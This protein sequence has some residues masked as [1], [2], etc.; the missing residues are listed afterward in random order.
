MINSI[1]APG[2]RIALRAAIALVLLMMFAGTAAAAESLLVISGNGTLFY[3]VWPAAD[4]GYLLGG[5][6]SDGAMIAKIDSAGREE[7][8]RSIPG[9]SP[10]EAAL[11]IQQTADGGAI[12]FSSSQHLIR[13]DAAGETLWRFAVTANSKVRSLD[14][15]SDGGFILAGDAEGGFLLKASEAG[16]EVWNQSYGCAER[17]QLRSVQPTEDGGF[18]LGGFNG[19][20]SGDTANRGLLIKTDPEGSVVWR[21]EYVGTD[22]GMI[23]STQPVPDGG[24]VAVRIAIEDSAVGDVVYRPWLMRTDG[25][26]TVLWQKSFAGEAMALY[27][28]LPTADGGY[29]LTGS[30]GGDIAG[31]ETYALIKTDPSGEIRWSRTYEGTAI[32]SVHQTADGG[33]IANGIRSAAAGAGESVLVR[34]D[35]ES[36]QSQKAPGFALPAAGAAL[37]AAF[38]ILRRRR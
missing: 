3:S 17:Y 20:G 15:T 19:Q 9:G 4:G 35:P 13:T 34:I 31:S 10:D 24:Y 25:N 2:H 21:Q 12:L 11:Y 22:G 36:G 30:N 27:Y 33:F 8:K 37:G 1:P 16:E 5:H 32:T 7:W 38:T 18:I 29:L 14:V 28:V 26:G 6:D 23:T